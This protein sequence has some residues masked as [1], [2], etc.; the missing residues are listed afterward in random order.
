MV[1]LSSIPFYNNKL[2]LI[3]KFTNVKERLE[4]LQDGNIYMNCLGI[5][6]KIEQEQGKKGVGDRYDGHS[7]ITNIADLTAYHPE[8]GEELGKI[9]ASKISFA[10]DAILAMPTFCSFAVD[11]TLLEII[12]ED[13]DSYLV[14]LV[15][16]SEKLERIIG[17]FGEHVLL[18]DFAVF[19]KEILKAVTEKGYALV[20]KRVKYADYSINQS[21]RLKD[22]QNIDI[23]FWKSDEFVHQNEHRFV[24]PTLGVETPLILQIGDLREHSQIYVARDLIAKPVRFHVPKPP[25]KAN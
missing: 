3:A 16:K 8:T 15:L 6:K 10:Y 25:K 1:S 2:H 14:E 19:T 23:A 4:S 24:I 7:V 11:S 22:G 13:E 18:I 21:M 17:D 5:Y 20:G 9:A 12:G